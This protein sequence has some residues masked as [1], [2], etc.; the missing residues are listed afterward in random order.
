MLISYAELHQAR[1]INVASMVRN[2]FMFPQESMAL[3]APIYVVQISQWLGTSFVRTS[4]SQ[5]L[6]R[7]DQNIEDTAKHFVYA[8]QYSTTL[9]SPTSWNS[10][11]SIELCRDLLYRFFYFSLYTVR[12]YNMFVIN[13]PV[14]YLDKFISLMCCSY[15]FRCVCIIFRQAL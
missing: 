6:S 4:P 12:F 15:M 7:S 9:L 1:S 5:L 11:L 2:S 3:V 10:R 8:L 14:H 13:Q